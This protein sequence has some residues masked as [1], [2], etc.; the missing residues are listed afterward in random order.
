MIV[1]IGDN[2]I[3]Y[4][5][6]PIDRKFAGGNVVNVVANLQ[7][8]GLPSAYIGTVGKDEFGHVIVSSL[9]K[10]GV[11]TRFIAQLEGPTGVTEIELADGEYLIRSEEYGVSSE[12]TLT[13]E[14]MHYLKDHATLIHLSLTGGAWR[15]AEA[16][17]ALNVPLSCDISNFYELYDKDQWQKLLPHLNCVFVSGGSAISVER[18][19]E[20]IGEIRSCGPEHIIVTRGSKG[21]IAYWDGKEVWQSS[22]IQAST[23]VDPLGAGDAFISGF[24]HS[25]KHEV[26]GI[27]QHLLQGSHWAAEACSRYGAW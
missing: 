22:L 11:N 14:A 1:G 10:L 2:C 8:H 20:I 18:I 3:D 26:N 12:V 23:V 4:Y 13:E 27:E 17:K 19:R 16:L 25:M 21:A 7:K 5:L 15:L 9:E 6:P 24:L